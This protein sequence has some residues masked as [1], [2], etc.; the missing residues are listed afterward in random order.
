MKKCKGKLYLP[1]PCSKPLPYSLFFR[2]LSFSPEG[3][4]LVPGNLEPRQTVFQ[5]LQPLSLW[6][7]G[8]LSRQVTPLDSHGAIW[9]SALLPPYLVL[10]FL[11][12]CWQRW[13]RGTGFG[14]IVGVEYDV[15]C[16]CGT[17]IPV[18]SLPQNG[19]GLAWVWSPPPIPL[20]YLTLE[21]CL[22]HALF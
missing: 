4:A 11:A 2:T 18:P 16:S 1:W 12:S 13:T 9:V 3:S 6:H 7:P 20:A 8:S 10:W 14:K 22:L 5:Q 17:C 15:T 21:C 19:R